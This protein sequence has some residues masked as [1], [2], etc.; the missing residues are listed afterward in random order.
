MR[1]DEVN[2]LR[3]VNAS[4]R[5]GEWWYEY[6]ALGN[7]TRKELT[8][9]AGDYSVE[10]YSYDAANRLESTAGGAPKRS[11]KLAWDRKGKLARTEAPGGAGA[12]TYAYDGQGRRVEKAEAGQTTV[13]HY[14]AAGRVMA[15]TTPDGAKIRDYYYLG[16]KLLAADA[17]GALG[18]SGCLEWYHTDTLGSV[19]ART[20]DAGVV[21]AQ[22][23]YQPFGEQW[24]VTGDGGDRQYNGRVFDPG[25]GF[26]DYGARLYWP[27]IGR[28]ISADSVMGSPG[29]PMTLNRY[30]YV[31]NNP[32]KYT[33]PTGHET[34]RQNRDIGQTEVTSNSDPY[35]HTF[36]FTTNPDGTVAHTYSWGNEANIRGWS[37]DQPEDRIAAINALERASG[38]PGYLN[39]L[40]KLGDSTLDPHVEKAFKELDKKE[41]EHQNLGVA[42]N[43]KTEATKLENRAKE[44]KKAADERKAVVEKKGSGGK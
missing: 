23:D 41:N 44:L 29:S 25:T 31:L 12:T 34:F 36:I 13:Y 11:L 26:H 30:S 6:D 9:P 39:R 21:V 38:A 35:S 22:L 28:F 15:E 27:E 3:A 7:R 10:Q 32:Y 42:R 19:W 1:Y 40:N 24:H 43:C 2:R 16:N 37:K 4:E 5:W 8:T 14:D 18:G 17:C 20:N 33:D